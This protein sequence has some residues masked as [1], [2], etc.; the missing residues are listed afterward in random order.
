MKCTRTPL[1]TDVVKYEVG[2]NLEDGFELFSDVVKKGWIALDNLVK[3]TREDGSIVCPYISHRRGKTF[4][5]NTDYIVSDPDGTKL[6]CGADK[7]WN[8]YQKL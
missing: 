7:I 6:V 8:R 3:V 2:M 4:I 1:V 5:Q